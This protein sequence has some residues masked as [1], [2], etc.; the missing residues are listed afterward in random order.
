MLHLIKLAVGVDEPEQIAPLQL[1]R[2]TA[3]GTVYHRTRMFPTRAAE[4]CPG[5][6][7]YWVV[8][9][10][11]QVR[12]PIVAFHRKTDDSGKS[13][14]LIELALTYV[15][16]QATARRPFQG[17]RYLKADD[18]PPDGRSAKAY[19]DPAMPAEM[20]RELRKLGLL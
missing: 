10:L 3:Q 7:L 15:P 18:A 12:Q 17:W 14:C 9:G 4:I 2:K 11:I 20:K 16:V 8:R 13:F 5:G 1:R 19:V 6:S